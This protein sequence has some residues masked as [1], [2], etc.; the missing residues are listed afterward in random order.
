MQLFGHPKEIYQNDPFK[1]YSLKIVG[2]YLASY[3]IVFTPFLRSSGDRGQFIFYK[4]H[5]IEGMSV[6]ETL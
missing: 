5:C 1:W 3:Y 4:I 6:F 2:V